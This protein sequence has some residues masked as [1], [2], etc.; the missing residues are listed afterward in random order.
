[1]CRRDRGRDGAATEFVLRFLERRQ[2][3]GC[4]GV[5]IRRLGRSWL[6]CMRLQ[7]SR[8][9]G[10]D[11]LRSMLHGCDGL[12]SRSGNVL[13]TKL[14]LDERDVGIFVPMNAASP[15]AEVGTAPPVRA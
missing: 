15:S 6:R 14:L 13:W 9:N 8:E 7:C 1:M 10:R 11:S 3:S 5:L 2:K 4:L 12:P